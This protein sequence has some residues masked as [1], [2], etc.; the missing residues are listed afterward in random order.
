MFENA[1]RREDALKVY[2]RT[3]EIAP[4][5]GPAREAA[6]RVRAALAGQAL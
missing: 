6:D 5:W 4:Q 3:L 2:E 1:G